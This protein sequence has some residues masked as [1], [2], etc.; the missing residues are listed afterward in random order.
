MCIKY[1]LICAREP[2]KPV[3]LIAIQQEL[4]YNL[5]SSKQHGKEKK[6]ILKKKPENDQKFLSFLY[7]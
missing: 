7:I 5:T 1:L 4:K 6:I 3:F 2:Q